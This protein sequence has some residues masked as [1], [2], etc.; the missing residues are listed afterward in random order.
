MVKQIYLAGGMSGLSYEEAN[1]WRNDMKLW[2]GESC[3]LINPNSYYNFKELSHDT[4]KEVRNFDL[5]FLR[6]SDLVI[7]N[8]N[9]P[10]SIGTAQ[11]VAVAFEYRI[12]VIGLNLKKEKLH[13][14]LLEC[15]DKLFS[16]MEDLID[17]VQF[18]YLG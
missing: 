8:F 1:Q 3:R 5:N 13:P 18:Y 9:E 10:G 6:H 2:L 15:C 4:E 16:T 12:P 7:V 11:E 14:W 17:Y